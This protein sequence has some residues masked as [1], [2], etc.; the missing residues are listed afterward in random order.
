MAT[1]LSI[2]GAK[3]RA[4]PPRGPAKVIPMPVPRADRHRRALRAVMGLLAI[5][6]AGAMLA[7][8]YISRTM[9]L[10]PEEIAGLSAPETE[11][12]RLVNDERARHGLKPLGFAPRLAVMARGHSYDMAIRKYLSHDS[13]EGSTPADRIRGVGISYSQLGENIYMDDFRDLDGLP[14]RAI[15][16]WLDSPEHRANMLSADFSATGVGIA[17]SLDGKSYV[18]Q[19]FIR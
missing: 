14:A 11:I 15:K 1:R 4:K 10:S 12:L 17:R 8:L 5:S 3:R 2:V 18:T 16:G 6:L 13:P 7:R 19:D 9:P